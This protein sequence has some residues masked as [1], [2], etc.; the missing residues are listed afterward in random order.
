MI[1]ATVCT[2][3]SSTSNASFGLL[4]AVSSSMRFYVRVCGACSIACRIPN[5]KPIDML[6]SIVVT[7][8]GFKA[9]PVSCILSKKAL[10]IA[11]LYGMS[12]SWIGIVSF[13]FRLF[14]R[15]PC[16]FL[17]A[18]G[19]VEVY[20]LGLHILVASTCSSTQRSIRILLPSQS[21]RSL[22]PL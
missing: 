18:Q 14:A 9:I 15:R 3:S 11:S 1:R 5:A 19:Q 7:I 8:P 20:I 2:R 13:I 6:N 16:G 10:F 21:L 4:I 17:G 22:R 12:F